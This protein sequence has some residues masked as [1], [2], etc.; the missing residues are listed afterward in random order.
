M[1]LQAWN[2]YAHDILNAVYLQ[3]DYGFNV[4]DSVKLNASAQYIGQSEV[5]DALAGDVDSNYW[6]VKLGTS[7]GALSGYV[8]YSQT[9]DSD[10]AMNG[11]VITPWGGMPA[12]TQGMVT[13][14]QFFADTYNNKSGSCI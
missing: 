9:G 2:Y 11:G 12:F 10:G 8:A 1:N 3:A 14:H 6:A 5:G 7:M 4:S 13:R